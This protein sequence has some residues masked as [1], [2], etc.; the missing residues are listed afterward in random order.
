[1]IAS[2]G[3]ILCFSISHHFLPSACF[4]SLPFRALSIAFRDHHRRSIKAGVCGVV[5]SMSGKWRD[6]LGVGLFAKPDESA[7]TN[8]SE[9]AMKLST[10]YGSTAM[11]C[12]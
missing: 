8:H 10:L 6:S 2:V 4:S 11:R 7:D 1:M 5:P 12:D 3:R 9:G